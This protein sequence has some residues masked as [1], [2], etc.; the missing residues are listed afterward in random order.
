MKDIQSHLCGRAGAKVLACARAVKRPWKCINP[1]VAINKYNKVRSMLP[2]LGTV[3]WTNS[4]AFH[5]IQ[6]KLLYTG[7]TASTLETL[8]SRDFLK[9]LYSC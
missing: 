7:L 3:G 6:I 2:P 9:S 8:G 4:L 5:P 1:T